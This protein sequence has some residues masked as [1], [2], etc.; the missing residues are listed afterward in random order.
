MAMSPRHRRMPRLPLIAGQ[1]LLLASVMA[2]HLPAAAAPAIT[3][4]KAEPETVDFAKLAQ[5]RPRKCGPDAGIV[6]GPHGWKEMAPMCVWQGRLQM[7]RWQASAIPTACVA[8]PAAW[9]AWQ[10]PRVGVQPASPGAAWRSAWK[11]HYLS[12]PG[13]SGI[14]RIATVEMREPGVWTATEWTWSPSP[15]AATRT[16]QQGRWKLIGEAA[17]KVRATDAAPSTPLLHAW[18]KNLAGRAG[19]IAHDGWRWN[20]N[21]K[22]LRMTPMPPA[23]APLPLPRAREDA[24]LEQRA[25][26]QIQLARRYPGATFLMPFRLLDAPES[27]PRSGAKYAAIWTERTNVTGQLW[28]PQKSGEAPVRAQVST[29]LPARYDTPSGLAASSGALRAIER[30]LTGIADTWS[31]DHER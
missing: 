10:R 20:S 28:I 23:S 4:K 6:A 3:R 13:D 7:R 25:A 14:E 26:M 5:H 8:R 9:L 29:T 27:A 18:E 1:A 11:S 12:G 19:E 31:A 21:G 22:C 24:R 2:A 30:E 17:S 16:W 15:R